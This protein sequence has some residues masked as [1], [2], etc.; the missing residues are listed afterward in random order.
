MV[1]P[2]FNKMNSYLSKY[3][4][5]NTGKTFYVRMINN[6]GFV[7]DEQCNYIKDNDYSFT[8]NNYIEESLL[9]DEYHRI[10]SKID[11]RNYRPIGIREYPGIKR[12]FINIPK[13]NTYVIVF[14]HNPVLLFNNTEYPTYAVA[15]SYMLS[16]VKNTENLCVLKKEDYIE[17][18]I[19]FENK[20]LYYK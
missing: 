16:H 5:I 15:V 6:Y 2:E 3:K 13:S 19:D 10:L 4:D 1:I 14:K 11:N 12:E 20:E 7:Y 9:P 8:D 17:R 18:L